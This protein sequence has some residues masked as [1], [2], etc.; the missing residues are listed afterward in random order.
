MII[1]RIVAAW[2][3]IFFVYLF[4]LEDIGLFRPILKLCTP[5]SGQWKNN[6]EFPLTQLHP[7]PHYSDAMNVHHIVTPLKARKSKKRRKV[8]IGESCY[9]KKK[10][11]LWLVKQFFLSFVVKMSNNRKTDIFLWFLQGGKMAACSF[12]CSL[13]TFQIHHRLR[14]QITV[15][16]DQY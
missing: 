15:I 13:S 3:A 2:I 9:A 16:F 6:L 5:L 14:D 4:C 12:L 11:N 7:R 10:K 8:A 1:C